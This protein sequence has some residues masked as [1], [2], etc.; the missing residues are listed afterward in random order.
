M[1]EFS[2]ND[3]RHLFDRFKTKAEEY[4]G[5]NGKAKQLLRSATEKVKAI[6]KQI[7]EDASHGQGPIGEV[8]AKA[9]LLISLFRDYSLGAY[10]QIPRSSIVA[11]IIGLL[12]FALPLDLVPDFIP[13][14]GLI[15]DLAVLAYVFRQVGSELERYQAWKEQNPAAAPDETEPE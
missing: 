2:Q 8:W 4:L 6:G 12:Y 11:I 5:D 10:R 9:Q 1:P 15:D 14:A 3:L 13:F 7:A